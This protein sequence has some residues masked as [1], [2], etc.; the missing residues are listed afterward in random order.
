[1]TKNRISNSLPEDDDNR[2]SKIEIGSILD[3]ASER[4]EELPIGE[5]DAIRRNSKESEVRHK[6]QKLADMES[7]F[8][9]DN[10]LPTTQQYRRSDGLGDTIN[11]FITGANGSKHSLQ[12]P[13]CVIETLEG[14][15]CFT[16]WPRTLFIVNK[17]D[18]RDE[19]QRVDDKST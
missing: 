17:D 6:R 3:A 13:Q 16:E 12:G 15:E 7:Q 5:Q 2:E 4:F 14:E 18:S 10:N 8:H 11:V 1:M 9:V 19:L